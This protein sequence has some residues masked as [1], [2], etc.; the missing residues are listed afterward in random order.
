[1]I[2]EFVASPRNAETIAVANN[3]MR[4]GL[5]SCRPRT[6]HGRARCVRTA[7]GPTEARRRAAS[8]DV[9][10]FVLVARSRRTSLVGELAALLN[11]SGGAG[12]TSAVLSIRFSPVAPFR[13]PAFCALVGDFTLGEALVEGGEPAAQ[14][15]RDLALLRTPFCRRSRVRGSSPARLSAPRGGNTPVYAAWHR[16]SS[17]ASIPNLYSLLRITALTRSSI[18]FGV[19]SLTR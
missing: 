9:R 5:L 19:R 11:A 18:R 16:Q 13:R 15:R 2:T 3:R 8:A 14:I 12:I 17:T 7:L 6:T 1:M 10:P 4:I